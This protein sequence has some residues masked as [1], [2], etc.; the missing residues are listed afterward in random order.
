MKAPLPLTLF[1]ILV[2]FAVPVRAG[3]SPLD[4]AV[5][6]IDAGELEK[7]VEIC[8]AVDGDSPLHVKAVYLRGEARLLL[9]K[10]AEAE[11]DFRAVLEEKPDAVPALTGLG[12]ALLAAGKAADAIAPLEKATDA[13]PKDA[14]AW[15][16][17]G[18]AL[19]AAGKKADAEKALAK[20]WKLEKKDPLVGRAFVEFLVAEDRL[21]EAETV[22]KG[23]AKARPKHPM[24]W[25]LCGYVL[26]R[27]GRS[28]EA[29]AMYEKAIERDET[30]LDAHKNIAIVC[31]A[32]N[33]TYRDVERTKKAFHHYQRYFDLGGRDESLRQI[34]LQTKGYLEQMGLLK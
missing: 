24:G 17:Y 19:A 18:R 5:K 4:R 1:L 23:L 6:A 21:P 12:R 29:I 31:H 28:D 20:A 10:P 33:P 27:D 15:C 26:D 32:V 3:D 8:S 16:A 2:A 14:A 13:A 34:Y 25:F 22:A 7:A 11:A 30:F 9:G